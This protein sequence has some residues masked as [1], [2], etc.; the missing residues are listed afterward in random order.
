MVWFLTGLWHG[1]NWT[2]ILW[3]CLYGVLI[4]GEKLS[5]WVQ[6][7]EGSLALRLFYQ[8]FTMVMVM[9]GWL[10]SRCFP[11]AMACLLAQRWK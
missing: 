3:G 6:K 11:R 9:L 8:P 7:V 4:A 2:F 1:A 10:L 5:G